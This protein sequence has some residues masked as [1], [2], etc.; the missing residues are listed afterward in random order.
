MKKFDK[1]KKIKFDYVPSKYKESFT[2][3]EAEE[4]YSEALR[5]VEWEKGEEWLEDCSDEE[6]K[7]EIMSR[8]KG[9]AEAYFKRQAWEKMVDKIVELIVGAVNNPSKNKN[10][11]IEK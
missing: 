10:P 11:K 1:Y 5:R 4:I 7:Q 2:E 6:I 9:V 3:Q 8:I